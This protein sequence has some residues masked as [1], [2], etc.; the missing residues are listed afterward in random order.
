MFVP[1]LRQSEFKTLKSQSCSQATNNSK[2]LKEKNKI[3]TCKAVV[4][5]NFNLH[6]EN[7]NL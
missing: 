3:Y 4:P 1:S 6:N 5:L 2:A 7:L